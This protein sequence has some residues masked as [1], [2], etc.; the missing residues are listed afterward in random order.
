MRHHMHQQPA[1]APRGPNSVSKSDQHAEVRGRKIT[2]LVVR[3][4]DFI[5]NRS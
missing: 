5:G 3:F 2:A 1:D 4:G